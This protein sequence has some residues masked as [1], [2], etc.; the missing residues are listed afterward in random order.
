MYLTRAIERPRRYL[1]RAIER[2]QRERL[3]A[4]PRTPRPEDCIWYHVMDV[5]GLGV[6]EAPWDLR[7]KFSEYIGSVPVE[8]RSVLDI[9]TASGFLS[10]EAEKAGAREI[11]SFDIGVGTSEHR[12]PFREKLYYTDRAAFIAQQTAEFDRWK[13]AYWLAHK[14]FGSQ[15]RAVYGDIYNLPV[16]LGTFDVVIVGA[17]LEHL[18]DPIGALESIS[19]LAGH[20]L[21][22]STEVIF[23]ETGYAR[24]VGNGH[25]SDH[26]FCF[27]VYS[28]GV[29][30]HVLKM[31]GFEI[32]RTPTSDFYYTHE[33]GFFPRTAIVAERTA[34]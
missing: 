13:N 10:F 20:T 15:A 23:D 2:A 5:P 18:R 22:I 27:W 24:F 25:D 30:R 3:F 6:T 12:L 1:T 14:A 9:G 8:G 32:V 11:V 29:Y 34:G 33:K 26:D 4:K 7:G 31:L 16:E 19:R 17:V 21:V 28:L